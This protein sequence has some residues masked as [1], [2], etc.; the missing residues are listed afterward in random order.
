VTVAVLD[1]HGTRRIE[2]T[3][4]LAQLSAGR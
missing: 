2:K 4:A 1:R 3:L